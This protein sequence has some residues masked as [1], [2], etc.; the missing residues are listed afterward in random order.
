MSTSRF[1][2][3]HRAGLVLIASIICV[4]TPFATAQSRAS[5]TF[6]NF[7]LKSGPGITVTGVNDYGTV[8]GYAD[9][10]ANASPRYKAF[11]HYSGGGTTYW[12]PSGAKQ[13]AFY[14][15][16]DSGLTTGYYYDATYHGHPFLLQG[17]KM[18]PIVTPG[19]GAPAGINNFD[20]EAGGY[21]DTNDKGHGF[22]R[23]SNGT[24]SILN[25]P[26]AVTTIPDGINDAGAIVGWYIGT[27]ANE[28]GFIYNKG[29]WATLQYPNAPRST[30][31]YG[32][33][34][35]GVI[36][37]QAGTHAFLY[38]NDTFK[39]IIDPGSKSTAAWAI[40]PGGLI[41]GMADLTHGF[42]ASCK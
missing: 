3:A 40:A 36:V 27:D 41:A 38:E 4:S 37:G 24:A 30:E 10:G 31:L 29:S 21:T 5:C 16:N 2:A 18:M 13:S 33:S 32:I 25:Y 1:L 22:K 7:T 9:F 42:L 12:I 20:S 23:Y 14:G 15:R 35:S 39:E 17:S 11:I 34:N 8:V 6:H 19:N 28:H 26:G